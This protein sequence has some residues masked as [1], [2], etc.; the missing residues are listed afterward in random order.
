MEVLLGTS[1]N[2]LKL[3]QEINHLRNHLETL[4]HNAMNNDDV[5]PPVWQFLSQPGASG[6]KAGV[7]R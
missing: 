7:D 3:R 4:R 6:L 5:S 2:V 1:A